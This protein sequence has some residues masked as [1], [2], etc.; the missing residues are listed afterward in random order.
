MA[1][2]T[3][4]FILMASK[5]QN[6]AQKPQDMQI[7]KSI[8]NPAGRAWGRPLASVARWIQMHWG[9]QTRAQMPQATQRG[10]SGDSS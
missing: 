1:S 10:L 2:L 6:S 4:W 3:S 5:G 7:V 8:Q 9:G